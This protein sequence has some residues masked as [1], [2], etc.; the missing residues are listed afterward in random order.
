MRGSIHKRGNTYSIVYRATDPTTGK[1]K[2]VWRGGFTTKKAAEDELKKVINSIDQGVYVAPTKQTFGEFLKDDWLPSLDNLVAGGKLKP[3]TAAFY[4]NLTNSHVIP[5]L[6]GVSLKA[7]DAPALNACYRD[8][9]KSGKVNG[10]GGLSLTTVHSIHVAISKALG[11]AVKWGKVARNVAALA[12]GPR[13][14]GSKR[15]VWSPDQLRTFL[16]SVKSDRL[17][18]LWLLAVTTGMRRGELCGLRW[19]DLDL[20]A[21]R[22]HVA[23][24]RVSVGYEVVTT[25]PKSASSDRSFGL[26]PA[27]VAALKAWKRQRT[28]ERLAWGP[29]WTDT[30]LVFGKEDGTPYHPQRITQAFARKVKAAK[31]PPMT[32]H[33]VRHA[34]ATAAL[35]AGVPIKVLSERLGHSSIQIT[36]DTYQHVRQQVDQNAADLTASFILGDAG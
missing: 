11:D 18:A 25:S 6:G 33:D 28:E 36:G 7:L 31:L 19:T 22:L 23:Q 12:D 21:Q 30:G 29:G 16:D 15:D 24:T 26:D 20:E 17:Y 1:T 34:Y 27:T 8:L 3:T 13:P 35:E 4:R 2:Q 5:R 10:D 32:V 14:N 9:L